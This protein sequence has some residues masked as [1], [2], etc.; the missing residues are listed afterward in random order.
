M[1]EGVNEVE[2]GL[3]RAIEEAGEGTRAR[4]YGLE[5]G[6]RRVWVKRAVAHKRRGWH[7]VQ[8]A[9][10]AVLRVDLLKVTND[11]EGQAAL[12][13][14]AAIIEALRAKGARVPEVLGLGPGWLALGDLGESL[15]L[16]LNRAE[17]REEVLGLAEAGAEALGVLHAA[18]GWHGNAQAR[19]LTGPMEEVGFIDFEENPGKQLVAAT[20]QAR[21]VLLYLLSLEAYERKFP[22]VVA[23]VAS[24]MKGRASR[25]V[26]KRLTMTRVLIAPL[27]WGVTPFARWLGRDARGAIC[28]YDVLAKD[29]KR[30]RRRRCWAAA[31]LVVGVLGVVYL[32]WTRF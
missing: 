21:D 1:S 6:G 30:A 25:L 27:V 9:A 10:A 5:W 31:W 26:A 11:T 24:G 20:C 17:T 29:A 12:E 3:R 15:R 32:A 8:A 14:E 22:G 7:R 4:V 19:N 2:V 18:G 16:V 23:E 13:R 28:L